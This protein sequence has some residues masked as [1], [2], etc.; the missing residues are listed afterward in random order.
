[1]R[2]I[3]LSLSLY[4]YLLPFF[5]RFPFLWV[6]LLFCV[7]EPRATAADREVGVAAAVTAEKVVGGGEFRPTRF[8]ERWNGSERTRN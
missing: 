6:F 1:M 3:P 7:G 2:S 8:T 5:L 4:S